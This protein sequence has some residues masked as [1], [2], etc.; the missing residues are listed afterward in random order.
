MR[1][2]STSRRSKQEGDE[3]NHFVDMESESVVQVYQWQRKVEGKWHHEE[4]D[5]RLRIS[6]GLYFEVQ[7]SFNC[8]AFGSFQGFE[9]SMWCPV[10]MG[11][12]VHQ[13][14]DLNLYHKLIETHH[15]VYY[16]E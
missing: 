15:I 8:S 16:T 12:L 3:V 9:Q 11:G 14:I 5:S 6:Y 1:F 13:P 4:V 7:A 2:A 10:S